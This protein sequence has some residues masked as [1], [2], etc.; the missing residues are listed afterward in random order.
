[1][2]V[3]KSTP[4]HRVWLVYAEDDLKVS[5]AVINL[6]HISVIPVLFHAQQCAEKA[7]KSYLIYHNVRFKKSHDLEELIIQ[8][9]KIN[10]E[11]QMSQ[12]AKPQS[13]SQSRY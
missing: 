6:A 4:K 3:D 7:L 10:N 11:F 8:C 13:C 9:I 1:M 12:L 5:K 2:K